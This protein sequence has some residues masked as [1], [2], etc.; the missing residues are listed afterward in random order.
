[1][2]E[3]LMHGT[4]ASQIAFDVDNLTIAFPGRGPGAG[5]FTPIDRFNL[6]ITAGEI[7]CI[8][9]RSGC[10]KTTLLRS[11]GGFIKPEPTGGVVYKGQYLTAP[12]PEVVLIFQENNLFPWLNVRQNVAFGARFRKRPKAE[13]AALV[14]RMIETVGLAEAA[15]AYPHQLSGGMR[16]RTA[17]ARALV[18]EPGILLLDEPF[19]ALDISL[20]RRMHD[21]LRT[22]WHDTRKT[23]VMV[24]HNVEEASVVGHRVIVLG[25]QP[26]RVLIDVDTRADGLKDRYS[27]EFL[28]LQRQIETAIY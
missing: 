15:G 19:S 10:G 12:T 28:N 21:L 1:V 4:A 14:D 8:L 20:R 7:T 25:G 11:L 16:Q 26:S 6:K 23:M 17:I 5:A 18:S 2:V 3:D 22:I 27:A 24:T 9:G 13:Q